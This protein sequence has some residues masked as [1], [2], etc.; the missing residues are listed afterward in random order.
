EENRIAFRFGRWAP[1]FG[2]G[3]AYE[4]R[5]PGDG[6]ARGRTLGRKETQLAR[7]RLE[8]LCR[9][10]GREGFIV[11]IQFFQRLAE[12]AERLE[13]LLRRQ[14]IQRGREFVDQLRIYAA[15]HLNAR[16]REARR[17]VI[18]RDRKCAARERFAI[19]QAVFSFRERGER[20][21]RVGVIGGRGLC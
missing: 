4:I 21:D 15:L 9:G 7:L 6:L 11:A 18:R 1:A 5:E 17:G 19:V 3:G 14:R 16:A 8:L 12:Q 10:E 2:I 13:A 20:G